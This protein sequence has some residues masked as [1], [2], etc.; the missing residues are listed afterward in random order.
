MRFEDQHLFLRLKAKQYD[1][2]KLIAA[3]IG[4]KNPPN[5]GKGQG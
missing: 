4:T 3:F 1:T 2:D 5:M